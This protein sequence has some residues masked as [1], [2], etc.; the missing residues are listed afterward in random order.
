MR[1]FALHMIA[2]TQFEAGRGP[3]AVDWANQAVESVR[4]TGSN[5]QP[6][7]AADLYFFAGQIYY[8]ASQRDTGLAYME[9]GISMAPVARQQADLRRLRDEFLRMYGG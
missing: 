7:M 4:A 8:R 9:Q 3:A 2:R 5:Y 6:Y 1:P